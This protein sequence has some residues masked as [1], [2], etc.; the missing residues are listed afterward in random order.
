MLKL[1]MWVFPD[2]SML[3][4]WVVP[5]MSMLGMWVLPDMLMLECGSAVGLITPSKGA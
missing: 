2:M 4:M 3:E 5:D 1:E